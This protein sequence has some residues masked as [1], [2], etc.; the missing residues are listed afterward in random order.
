VFDA[1]GSYRLPFAIAASLL[2]AAAL[3]SLR[4]SS[5]VP[6]REG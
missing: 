3:L 6:A 5:L 1:S 4:L 2:F